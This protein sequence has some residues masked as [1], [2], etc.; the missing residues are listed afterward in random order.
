M[1]GV[2]V[3]VEQEPSP[4]EVKFWP[5][6][7]ATDNRGEFAVRLPIVPASYRVSVQVSGYLPQTKSVSVQGE[8]RFDLSFML[9]QKPQ[10]E[11]K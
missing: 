4:S 1:S 10:G 5:V 3:V 9:D 2:E 8:Q 7:V 11:S 6:K